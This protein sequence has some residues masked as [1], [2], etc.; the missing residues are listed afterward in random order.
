MA[1][2]DLKTGP[3]PEN[4]LVL[5]GFHRMAAFKEFLAKASSEEL[6]VA[7]GYEPI[8]E[9]TLKR[10]VRRRLKLRSTTTRK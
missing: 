4:V 7:L 3:P 1:E 2:N 6:A 9:V 8:P 5:D 10:R